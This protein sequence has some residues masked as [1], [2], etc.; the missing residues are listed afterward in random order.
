MLALLNI[1][2]KLS[3]G[4]DPLS[5]GHGGRRAGLRFA[6]V[7]RLEGAGLVLKRCGAGRNTP[8]GNRAANL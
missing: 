6:G 4:A 7:A 5:T 3:K 8:T 1:H 2:E